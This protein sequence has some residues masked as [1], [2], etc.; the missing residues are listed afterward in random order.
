LGG[1]KGGPNEYI[2]QAVLPDGYEPQ[3]VGLPDGYEP[4]VVVLPD[5]PAVPIVVGAPDQH[6]APLGQKL[7][8]R[9]FLKIRNP[10]IITVPYIN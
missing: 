5:G 6:Q 7:A 8:N 1:V 9:Y 10:T 2:L 4:Q 3:V